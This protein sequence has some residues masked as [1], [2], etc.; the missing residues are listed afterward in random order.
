[1]LT[2]CCYSEAAEVDADAEAAAPKTTHETA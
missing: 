1:M 2:G